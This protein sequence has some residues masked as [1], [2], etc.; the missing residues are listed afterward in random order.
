MDLYFGKK[1]EFE[2]KMSKSLICFLQEKKKTA[3]HDIRHWLMDWN[4]MDYC[5]VFYQLFGSHSDGTHSLQMIHWWTSDVMQHF[6]KSVL[7]KKQNST[8]WM[9][10]LS[11]K[12]QFIVEAIK[13]RQMPTRTGCVTCHHHKATTK[14]TKLL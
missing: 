7:M 6:S 4:C 13:Y 3:I 2:V 5:D 11:N 14:L 12:N 8:S 10:C 1:Q 9:A